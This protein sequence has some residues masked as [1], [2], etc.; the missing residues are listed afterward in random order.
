MEIK[1]AVD[2]QIKSVSGETNSEAERT[3]PSKTVSRGIGS[4]NSSVEQAIQPEKLFTEQRE[5]RPN[6]PLTQKQD[7]VATQLR[8]ASQGLI[9]KPDVRQSAA[10]VYKTAINDLAGITGKSLQEVETAFAKHGIDVGK[11]VSLS[12]KDAAAVRDDLCAKKESVKNKLDSMSEMGEMES[13]RMQMAMD[14]LSKLMSTL[15]NLLKKSS[16]TGQSITQNI[17]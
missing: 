17:K 16:S 6:E 4:L 12:S 8:L 3:Q 15:S 14:R 5:D 9:A 1:R 2:T 10:D 7:S 13:L 11:D